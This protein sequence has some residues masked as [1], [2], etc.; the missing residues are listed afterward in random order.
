M[1]VG[2]HVGEPLSQGMLF[3]LSFAYGDVTSFLAVNR[4]IVAEIV[5]VLFI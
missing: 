3:Q 4:P 2:T 1:K 5:S